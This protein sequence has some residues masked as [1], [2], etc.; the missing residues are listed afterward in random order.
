MRFLRSFVFSI[1]CFSGAE[2][3]WVGVFFLVGCI[4]LLLWVLLDKGKTDM[5]FQPLL[6]RHEQMIFSPGPGAVHW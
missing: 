6:I 5:A 1:F 4:S 3:G 2:Q